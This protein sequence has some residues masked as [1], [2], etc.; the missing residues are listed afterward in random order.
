MPEFRAIAGL[1]G[2]LRSTRDKLK[3]T[4][5]GTKKWDF[6]DG[7]VGFFA[8]SAFLGVR[9]SVPE[10]QVPKS[11]FL[12]SLLGK[13][14]FSVCLSERFLKVRRS[15]SAGS[16]TENVGFFAK[17]GLP[18]ARSGRFPDNSVLMILFPYAYSQSGTNFSD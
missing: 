11:R 16:Q 15:V 18:G 13:P 7:F 14:D 5:C 9:F 6:W 10:K 3:I 17:I 1:S 12:A 8:K 4:V 2:N